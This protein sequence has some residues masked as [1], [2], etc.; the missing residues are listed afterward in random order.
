MWR[1]RIWYLVSRLS[2]AKFFAYNCIFETKSQEKYS[3]MPIKLAY[4]DWWVSRMTIR[5]RPPLSWDSISLNSSFA[6][7]VTNIFF[8]CSKLDHPRIFWRL[9]HGLWKIVGLV[10]EA[11]SI[12]GPLRA[13]AVTMLS[14]PGIGHRRSSNPLTLRQ[15]PA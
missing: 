2:Y 11:Y 7:F 15:R 12:K 14:L 3:P 9:T 10:G 1:D 8:L 13:I 5:F 4:F 6:V